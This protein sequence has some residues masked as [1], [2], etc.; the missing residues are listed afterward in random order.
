MRAKEFSLSFAQVGLPPR[1]EYSGSLEL[2]QAPAR[3][4]AERRGDA[5]VLTA[6]ASIFFLLASLAGM[7]PAPARQRRTDASGGWGIRNAKGF[8]LLSAIHGIDNR[9]R[10]V[11]F[12]YL[13]PFLLL[14]KGHTRN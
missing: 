6:A 5:R 9:S 1:S 14:G 2:F 11:F 7:P 13:L 12:T 4:L 3:H 10:T 8:T